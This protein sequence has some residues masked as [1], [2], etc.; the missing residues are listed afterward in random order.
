MAYPGKAPSRSDSA[1][2]TLPLLIYLAMAIGLWWAAGDLETWLGLSAW[3]RALRLAGCV[4]GGAAAYFVVLWLS[5]I[6]FAEL[7]RLGAGRG[8]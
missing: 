7:R 1:L 6:R 2:S 3:Q 4:G 8:P 5:G